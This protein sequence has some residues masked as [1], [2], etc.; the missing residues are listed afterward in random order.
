MTKEGDIVVQG[1]VVV[2]R[3]GVAGRDY[4]FEFVL[5]KYGFVVFV[6]GI[7]PPVVKGHIDAVVGAL[8]VVVLSFDTANDEK[9]LDEAPPRVGLFINGRQFRLFRFC[10]GG[11]R[12]FHHGVLDFIYIWRWLLSV[13]VSL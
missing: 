2:I 8:V 4:G 10:H 11:G 5:G 3:E 6:V 9:V 7:R 13:R 12:I 1:I